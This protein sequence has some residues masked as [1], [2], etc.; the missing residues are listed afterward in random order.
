MREGGDGCDHDTA[1]VR[2]HAHYYVN[3][4]YKNAAEYKFFFF[5]F[6]F[7]SKIAVGLVQFTHDCCVRLCILYLRWRSGGYLIGGDRL[8]KK[9]SLVDF[10]VG[11]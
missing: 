3:T 6:S 11:S 5:F 4:T 1:H 10:Y 8:E 7:V 9:L 2:L